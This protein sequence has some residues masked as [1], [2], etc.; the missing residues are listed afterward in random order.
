M[1]PEPRCSAGD[2]VRL[3]MSLNEWLTTSV[4]TAGAA[5]T[6]GALTWPPIQ[7]A[8]GESVSRT[9]LRPPNRTGDHQHHHRH[10]PITDWGANL[11]GVAIISQAV[12]ETDNRD[13]RKSTCQSPNQ[14]IS[15][16]SRRVAGERSVRG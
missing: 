14:Q 16:L 2:I 8:P 15:T 10:P 9:V 4:E 1:N 6:E 13:V 5:A 12:V 11:N 7:L 3:S